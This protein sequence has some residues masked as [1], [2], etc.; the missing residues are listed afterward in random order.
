MFKGIQLHTL[1][2]VRGSHPASPLK[3][4]ATQQQT[5]G[6]GEDGTTSPGHSLLGE[7]GADAHTTAEQGG[8]LAA[9]GPRKPGLP[10]HCV[11][12][13]FCHYVHLPPAAFKYQGR[14]RGWDSQQVLGRNKQLWPH[15]SPQEPIT[16]QKE[17]QVPTDPLFHLSEMRDR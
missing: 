4:P 2:P 13:P 3:S 17:N 12:P 7:L 16:S 11:H 9:C 1:C 5:Q 15:Y 8:S 6:V 14:P 10:S